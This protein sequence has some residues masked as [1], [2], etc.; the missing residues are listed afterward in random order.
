[1]TTP[2]ESVAPRQFRKRPVVIEAQQWLGPHT[3]HPEVVEYTDVEAP[4]GERGRYYIR[5]LESQHFRV[6][7]GDWI[8]RGVAGEFY[9]CQ[10]DIFAATYEPVGEVERA[11]LAHVEEGPPTTNVSA[12]S[13]SLGV[14]RE[15]SEA[16]IRAAD[17]AH[18]RV[19]ATFL[20]GG[21]DVAPDTAIREALRA[22]YA[23]DFGRAGLPQG[24]PRD[25]EMLLRK[26]L[27]LRHGCDGLY[28]DDGE[29]QCGRCLID[30]KRM[31]PAD[32]QARW[33]RE[34]LLH[35]GL[36]GEP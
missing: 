36:S 22:A 28:G 21:A 27:W 13:S 2:S 23:V 15:P 4:L 18:D 1:M 11:A 16:A 12:V 10:P 35:A 31:S 14:S 17:A 19:V 30:F 3:P 34:N 20:D 25:D 29:M 7:P 8:I 26:L 9:A 24:A 32:I 33:V 5:T 6:M